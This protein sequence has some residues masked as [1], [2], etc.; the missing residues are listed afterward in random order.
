MLTLTSVNST[1]EIDEISPGVSGRGQSEAT[2]VIKSTI[3]A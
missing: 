1:E 2:S 3:H